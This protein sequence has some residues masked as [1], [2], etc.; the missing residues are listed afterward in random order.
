MDID[1]TLIM[2]TDDQNRIT[3]FLM[4]NHSGS[5]GKRMISGGQFQES[6]SESSSA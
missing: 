4:V 5:I 2:Y 6:G 3:K 1:A